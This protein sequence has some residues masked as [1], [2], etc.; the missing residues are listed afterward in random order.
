MVMYVAR[1]KSF[2]EAGAVQ[3]GIRAACPTLI[4]SRIL[5]SSQDLDSFS[6]EMLRSGD[7]QIS[8]GAMTFGQNQATMDDSW[9]ILSRWV[10][11]AVAVLVA[12][13]LA[14]VR[15]L[16]SMPHT[17]TAV[18]VLVAAI[19]LVFIL[20]ALLGARALASMTPERTA[21]WNATKWLKR[22]RPVVIAA[23]EESP[24]HPGRLPKTVICFYRASERQYRRPA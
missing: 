15:I 18:A 9:R 20:F 6:A 11:F 10:L 8:V 3:H 4:Y 12:L 23:S 22:G 14:G 21:F 24:D 5:L 7:D 17:N 19:M 13:A 2:A 16:N 1:C